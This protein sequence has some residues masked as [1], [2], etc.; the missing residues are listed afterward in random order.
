MTYG[1]TFILVSRAP[2]L[3]GRMTIHSCLPILGVVEAKGRREVDDR[4]SLVDVFKVKRGSSRIDIGM[5]DLLL[6]RSDV[7]PKRMVSWQMSEEPLSRWWWGVQ[8][9]S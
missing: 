4:V 9:R 1:L 7:P 2:A 8:C 3:S 5:E 6:V